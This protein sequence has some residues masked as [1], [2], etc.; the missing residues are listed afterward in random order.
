MTEVCQR[1]FPRCTIF[2]K[3]IVSAWE[4]LRG[5]RVKIEIHISW[6]LLKDLGV[7]PCR[8]ASVGIFFFSIFKITWHHFFPVDVHF[9]RRNLPFQMF[10]FESS[11]SIDCLGMIQGPKIQRFILKWSL[12]WVLLLFKSVLCPVHNF[13]IF[14]VF[15]LISFHFLAGCI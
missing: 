9:N 10:Q 4:V 12:Y 2:V 5:D 11:C 6:T 8:T 1:P 13:T 14:L 7:C 15:L 3:W